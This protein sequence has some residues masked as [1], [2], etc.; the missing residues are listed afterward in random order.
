M[1][2]PTSIAWLN[3]P[4]GGV[5][6]GEVT[7]VLLMANSFGYRTLPLSRQ[8]CPNVVS[9]QDE[10]TNQFTAQKLSVFIP[11]HS[12][13]VLDLG[14]TDDFLGHRFQLDAFIQCR[15]VSKSDHANDIGLIG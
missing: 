15:H 4:T 9:F 6:S 11:G 5:S 2:P 14:A 12:G 3:G 13:L 1:K 7:A 10:F 8:A